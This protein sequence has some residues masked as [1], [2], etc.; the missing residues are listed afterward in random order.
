MLNRILS[1]RDDRAVV[2]VRLMVGLVVFF[3]EGLQ[4][5]LFPEISAPVDSRRSAFPGRSSCRGSGRDALWRAHHSWPLHA[6]RRRAVD[7]CHATET[8]CVGSSYMSGQVLLVG[9]GGSF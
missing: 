1:T 6:G 2:L 9:G 3:P 7:H 5:L 8:T 4:K